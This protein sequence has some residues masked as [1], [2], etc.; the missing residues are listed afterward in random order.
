[1]MPEWIQRESYGVGIASLVLR[2]AER[3]NALCV[4]L[5]E[6]LC[7]ALESLAADPMNRVVLLRGDGPVFSAG[8]D[9][10]EAAN[11][12]LIECSAAGISRALH[13]LS[14]GPLVT[15]AVVQGGAF[16]GGAGLMAACDIVIAT[17]DARIGF[18]EARRGLLPALIGDVLR[19]RVREGDLRDLLLTGT[20]IDALRARQVGLVQHIVPP[21][22]LLDEALRIAREVLA[23]GP[24]TIR[25]TK[26]LVS[27]LYGRA[28]DHLERS[29][30]AWHLDA[31]RS[32][33]AREGLRA[34]LEKREPPWSVG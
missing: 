15:I 18:P 34:F 5:L 30:E 9:L 13:L 25:E 31:R 32:E 21:A 27:A 29:M 10:H 19:T 16:A 11:E 23:G 14:D 12:V 6:Q 33:E 26:Q 20:S 4:G 2:R 7:A 1:M 3:R 28:G 24:E 8:L 22:R 17:D